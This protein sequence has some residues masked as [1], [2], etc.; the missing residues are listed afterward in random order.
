MAT[1]L[2]C[3]FQHDSCSLQ[4][5]AVQPD[6]LQEVQYRSV[7]VHPVHSAAYGY[8]EKYTGTWHQVHCLVLGCA[9]GADKEDLTREGIP[10]RP[11]D[12][13]NGFGMELT[14]QRMTMK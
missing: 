4:S 10:P 13:C 6:S 1:C 5:L 14:V 11:S 7:D 12:L 2:S 8:R 3:F 9:G